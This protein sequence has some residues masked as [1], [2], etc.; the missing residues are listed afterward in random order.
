MQRLLAKDRMSILYCEKGSLEVDGFSLVLRSGTQCAQL[1]VGATNAIFVMPGTVVTHAAV[2]VC[3][4]EG[5]LLVWVGE[6]GVRT[7]SSGNPGGACAEK[8]LHQASLKLDPVKQLSVA[9]KMYLRMFGQ[10]LN[11][12]S[13][14]QL[15]GEEGARV[16]VKY[17]ELTKQSGVINWQGRSTSNGSDPIN[18]AISYANAA[19]YGITEAVI[20]ALGYSPAL[21]FVHTGNSR[22]F[23]F[24]IADCIKF[25]TT[26][27]LGISV[28][29]ESPDNIAARTRRACRDLF[30]KEKLTDKLVDLVEDVLS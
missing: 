15:R 20:L 4:D 9:K 25:E 16:K 18:Q 13:I 11:G 7:Y 22:S 28:A 14:E 3:A 23:V 30:A 10:S 6:N 26:V 29:V 24:D 8:I 27:P 21:G 2:K 19:L 17:R 1:P 5:S 12:R